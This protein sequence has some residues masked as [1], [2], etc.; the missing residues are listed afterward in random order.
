MLQK[1]LRSRKDL[2]IRSTLHPLVI[3]SFA[4]LKSPC[5]LYQR[6]NAYHKSESFKARG[7][8]PALPDS[9]IS[10]FFTISKP[11]EVK[12]GLV[13]LPTAQLIVAAPPQDKR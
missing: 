1:K 7:D 6:K 3:R 4:S 12:V 8:L 13:K 2:Q 9:E 10:S 11:T 5:R